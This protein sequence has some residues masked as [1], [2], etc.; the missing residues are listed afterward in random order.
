MDFIISWVDPNDPEWQQEYIKHKEK[1]IGDSHLARFRDWDNLHFWFRGIEKFAPWVEKIHFV[2]WGHVP[3]WLDIRNPI[4]HIVNHADFIPTKYLP[5]FSSRAIDL[6]FHRIDGLSENYVYFNDDTF[7]IDKVKE[8]DFFKRGRPCDMGVFS[9]LTGWNYN[10]TLV[11]NLFILNKYF[12]KTKMVKQK[13]FNWFNPKYGK[14]GIRNLLLF[15]A[16]KNRYTGFYNPH[17]PSPRRKGTLALLWEKEFAALDK[18]CSY[19]FRNY[20]TI[21]EYLQRYWELASNNF[22]PTDVRKLGQ[23]LKLHNLDISFVLDFIIHRKKP[24]ICLNDHVDMKFDISFEN[25]R[26]KIREAFEQILPEK[27]SFEI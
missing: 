25:T 27:S 5:T 8:T 23:E 10:H 20:N 7:L 18:S 26:E 15:L 14:E 21:N 6:N 3:K 4:L 11:E 16:N 9:E 19:K 13:P 1:E 22:Y 12:S 2:T 24:M 17:I